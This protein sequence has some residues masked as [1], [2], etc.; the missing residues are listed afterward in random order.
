VL[1]ISSIVIDQAITPRYIGSH[2][3]LELDHFHYRDLSWYKS[4]WHHLF[5][6]AIPLLLVPV[7]HHTCLRCRD[8]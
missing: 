7:I 2:L 6:S 5:A 1:L 8:W 4:V 3:M